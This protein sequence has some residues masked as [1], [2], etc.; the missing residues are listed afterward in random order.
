M[1]E[2]TK[3]VISGLVGVQKLTNSAPTV[4]SILHPADP[5]A[6]ISGFSVLRPLIDFM[7]LEPKAP[8]MH[9]WV[10]RPRGIHEP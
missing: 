10:P 5:S 7:A 8:L 3:V 6:P 9:Q 1:Y 4:E 2:Y